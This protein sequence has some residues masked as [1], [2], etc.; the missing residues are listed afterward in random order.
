MAIALGAIVAGS[1]LW[2]AE[3][4][5]QRRVVRSYPYPVRAAV[6]RPYSRRS[7]VFVGVRFA[8][9]YYWPSFGLHGSWFPYGYGYGFP[10]AYP[11]G[12]P[13]GRYGPYGY[14]PYAGFSSVRLQV[15]PKQTEVFI[16]GYWAGTVDDFDGFFQRLSLDPG[17][18]DLELYLEGHRSVRQKI[19]LQP[20]GT[21]RIRHMMVPLAPGDTP[22]PRPVPPAGSRPTRPYDSSGR[23]SGTQRPGRPAPPEREPSD[24]QS[25]GTLAI[26]VQPGDAEIV[27][28]GES[29]EAPA[30]SDRL[31]V[32]LTEGEHRLEVR[33]DGFT[34]Y[35][36]SVRVRGG[37]TVTLN[38]SLARE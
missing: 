5:A 13:Y 32:Q 25:F 10:Y 33:K 8:P 4:H 2:P 29:W 7:S 27:I 37:E 16:D 35:A 21:F 14:A 23:P 11:Y 1:M 34:T 28:D 17:D 12:Y 38:I 26:R 31:E 3:A 15:E 19:Y 9:Y 20:N 18:H 24:Q 22:D 36:S 6:V 30:T